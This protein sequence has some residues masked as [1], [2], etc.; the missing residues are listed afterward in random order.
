M[1][2]ATRLS[3][4]TTQ[5]Q[6]RTFVSS[7]TATPSP[8]LHPDV[9]ERIACAADARAAAAAISPA[10][11]DALV[12]AQGDALFWAGIA[13]EEALSSLQRRL[14]L[15]QPLPDNAA[16]EAVQRRLRATQQEAMASSLRKLAA[17]AEQAASSLPL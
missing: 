10:D 13:A 16:P 14:L 5:S 1:R 17:S 15:E 6:W 7:L 2:T 9:M 8:G 12:S 11:T 4:G 3:S